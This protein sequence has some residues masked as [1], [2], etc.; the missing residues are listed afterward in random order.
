VCGHHGPVERDGNGSSK[1]TDRPRKYEDI[2][3]SRCSARVPCVRPHGSR[4]SVPRRR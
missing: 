4:S 2:R 1:F 3:R